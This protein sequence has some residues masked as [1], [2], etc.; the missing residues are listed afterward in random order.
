VWIGAFVT[1]L[2]FSVGKAIIGIYLGNSAVAST[3][4][5]AGSLVLLLLWIYYSAQILFF[6]AEFT[7]VYANQYS[8]KTALE[9][10]EKSLHTEAKQGTAP[11]PSAAIAISIRERQVER[12]NRQTGR[13][14]L[15]I[16]ITAYLTGIFTVIFGLRKR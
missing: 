16:V 1:S 4:G 12:Q 6:G 7:Q 3:F 13:I 10:K 2:L 15:G 11:S 14:F 8:S 5:A 9:G